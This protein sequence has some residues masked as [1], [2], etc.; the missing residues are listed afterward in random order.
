V[1]AATAPPTLKTGIRAS[2]RTVP[3]VVGFFAFVLGEHQ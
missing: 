3:F 1:A 2:Q